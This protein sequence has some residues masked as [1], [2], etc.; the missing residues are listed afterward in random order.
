LTPLRTADSIRARLAGRKGA[1]MKV[2]VNYANRRFRWHQRQNS[3]SALAVGGFERVCSFSPDDIDPE[4]IRKNCHILG[5]ERGNGYWLWKPYVIS[6]VLRTLGESDYLFYC[7]AGAQFVASIDPLIDVMLRDKLNLMVFEL[8]LVE[9]DWTKRDALVLLDCDQPE[10][11]ESRQR[12]ASFHLWRN[13][14]LALSIADEW[15]RLAQDERLLTDLA[16][17][18]GL[19]NH[20]GFREHRHDQSLFSLL[21]KKLGL[22]AYRNPAHGRNRNYR[23]S[24]YGQ[25]IQHTR[26]SG[27]A[28]LPRLVRDAKKS[29]AAWAARWS[30]KAA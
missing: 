2:L 16:N 6:R 8:P 29:I 27:A 30:R 25:L 23:N 20:A 12:L 15:L 24:P 11:I 26:R 5:Q 9:G 4:F 13:S 17:Q 28:W 7:D 18:C 19:P 21:T 1:A 22:P 10:F 14:P 3:R